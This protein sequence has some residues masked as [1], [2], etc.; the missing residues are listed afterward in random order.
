MAAKY[1][2]EDVLNIH[3]PWS[4]KNDDL[5]N[6][7]FKQNGIAVKTVCCESTVNGVQ[8][9]IDANALIN[10]GTNILNNQQA[11]HGFYQIMLPSRE[12]FRCSH[13]VAL[14]IDNKT[15]TIYY[16][17]S[18]GEDMRREMSDFLRLLLPDYKMDINHSKQQEDVVN[19]FITEENDNSCV[20]LAKYNLRDMWYKIN[21]QN[22]KICN[23]SSVRARKDAWAALKD[24]KKEEPEEKP[25]P[26]KVTIK[27]GAQKTCVKEELEKQ[28]QAEK[29]DF[30]YRLYNEPDYIEILQSAVQKAK[31]NHAAY[32]RQMTA[33][34]GG[35]NK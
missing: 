4:E 17:D 18:H 28:K 24:I 14:A 21:G 30:K 12:C 34:R 7:L 15:E 23:F 32:L 26:T 8:G 5:D 3:L 33:Q 22:D 6:V 16:H 10:L 20:L 29:N 19:H 31:C 27:F 35:L 9:K 2:E 25:Q 1:D 13:A 11:D